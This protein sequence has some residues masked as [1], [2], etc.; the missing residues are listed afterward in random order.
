MPTK[1]P[2]GLTIRVT[3]NAREKT[4]K[5]LAY[6]KG[7]SKRAYKAVLPMCDDNTCRKNGPHNKWVAPLGRHILDNPI[8]FFHPRDVDNL[9]K[10]LVRSYC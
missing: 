3:S 8:T 6:R 1:I 10:K 4:T 7:E 9:V 5:I 2:D